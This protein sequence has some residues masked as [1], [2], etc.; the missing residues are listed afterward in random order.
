MPVLQNRSSGRAG[1]MGVRL[2]RIFVSPLLQNRPAI[3]RGQRGCHSGG[4]QIFVLCATQAFSLAGVFC[5][6][7]ED[8]PVLQNR[9][10]RFACTAAHPHGRHPAPQPPPPCAALA[11]FS[12]GQGVQGMSMCL[13]V[14]VSLSSPFTSAPKPPPW[15]R[16]R[17]PLLRSCPYRSEFLRPDMWAGRQ[18]LNFAFLWSWAQKH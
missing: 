11:P 10:V 3:H 9:G 2:T 17:E 14:L 18:R 5:L 1:Y 13:C 8:L 12:H 4:V 15:N 16:G 6:R 7:S